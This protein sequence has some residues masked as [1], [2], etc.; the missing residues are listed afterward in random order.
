[1]T[2][3]ATDDSGDENI[4]EAKIVLLGSAAVGKSA[5]ALK[6]VRDEFN[7]SLEATVGACFF[8]KR[9]NIDGKDI[10]LQI[11]DTAGQERF[12]ALTPLYYR[13]SVGALLV[14]DMA[15]QSSF[16]GVQTWME[17]LQQNMSSDMV[18]IV[19]GAK[20]DLFYS[21]PEAQRLVHVPQAA[22]D[23][24]KSKGALYFETS[25]KTGEGI[26]ELFQALA[27]EILKRGLAKLPEGAGGDGGAGSGGASGDSAGGNNAPTI[28][29]DGSG[30]A[31]NG[32]SSG[33]KH[34]RCGLM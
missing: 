23:Y 8:A 9:L 24:A 5:L 31:S 7:E 1:M 20:K 25:A 18:L 12:H 28:R 14:F 6:Y 13:G 10:R 32:E 17:E 27:A 4:A 29:L 2:S 33:K 3:P 19:V 34:R 30:N 11:W 21:V 22:Q 15:D 16:K 26:N